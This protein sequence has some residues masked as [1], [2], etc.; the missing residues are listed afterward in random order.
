[1]LEGGTVLIVDTDERLRS[2]LKELLGDA[3]FGSIE[4]VTG[5]DA[6]AL[7]RREQ[8]WLVV[9]DVRLPDISGYEVCREL[10]DEFGDGLG[11]VFVSAD[12]TEPMDLAA[13]LLVG[14]DDYMAKPFDASEMLARIRRLSRRAAFAPGP[15]PPVVAM[16]WK[17]T[18]RELEVL[19]QLA[20][21]HRPREIATALVI[22]EKTVSSHL[23][24][25]LAKLG[26][27]SRTQAVA[28]AYRDGL[29]E[30][31]AGSDPRLNGTPLR[32]GRKDT[33]LASA[34]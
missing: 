2:E 16:D 18:S 26:V 21:G 1:M 24:R 22:S 32:R 31:T 4:A 8:P 14:A 29:I 30:I 9:L 19:K 20:D 13:G 11:I 33:P 7:A 27:N 5:R 34:F 3:G 23:Q 6:V 17:L 25:V 28:V 15:A 12:R 10:R